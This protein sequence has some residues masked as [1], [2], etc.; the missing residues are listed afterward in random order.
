MLPLRRS[1]LV[2]SALV[3]GSLA[4]D[5][6]YFFLLSEHVR[7]GHSVEGLFQ[8]CIPAGLAV[9][10]VFHVVVKR[11]LVDLA[12]H[13]IRDRIAPSDLVFRFGLL[14]RFLRI[15]GSLLVGSITHILWDGFTHDHGYFVKHWA[16]LREQVVEVPH[17]P[18]LFKL[19]QFGCSGIGLAIIA[20]VAW[21]VW[22]RKPLASITVPSNIGPRWRRAISALI[23]GFTSAMGIAVALERWHRHLAWKSC[24]IEGVIYS[25]TAFCFAVLLYSL[26]WRVNLPGGKQKPLGREVQGLEVR[27]SR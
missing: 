16:L 13:F 19:L 23:L 3:V 6:P 9:L 1:R 24:I 4:P 17:H 27:S 26:L 18:P 2:F 22:N 14:S 7:L 11:P 20:W 10:W 15:L 21:R 8:F 25:I 12:P 5:F